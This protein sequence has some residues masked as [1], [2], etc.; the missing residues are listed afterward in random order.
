MNQPNN[1]V[2]GCKVATMC[3]SCFALSFSLSQNDFFSRLFR[4]NSVFLYTDNDGR[5]IIVLK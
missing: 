5:V 2:E 4:Y 1:S 3:A